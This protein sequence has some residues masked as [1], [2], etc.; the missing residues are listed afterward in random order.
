MR[1][2]AQHI[3]YCFVSLTLLV[4]ECV[5]GTAF[6]SPLAEFQG[7]VVDDETGEP[8]T[9]FR[10]QLGMASPQKPEEISWSQE[11]HGPVLRQP[12]FFSLQSIK[13]GKTWAR[14]L[15]D[16]YLPQPVTAEPVVSPV[17]ITD[18][19]VR[20]KR[21]GELRGIVRNHAG[22]AVAG[23]RV[24]LATEQSLDLTDGNPGQTFRGSTAITDAE[25]RF[26]L[27][28]VGGT[29]QKVVVLSADG[30]QIWIAPKAETGQELKITLPEPAT[31][32]VRYDIPDDAPK[33][34]LR[35]QLKTWELSSMKGVTFV[36]QPTVTNQG[37]VVLTDLAPGTYDLTRTKM[38][39]VGTEAH[40]QFY[41]RSTVVLQAAQT[42]QV[43]FVRTTGFPVRGEVV[44][45]T[46][47]NASGAFI[48]VR[49]AE[50]TGDPRKLQ[51]LMLPLFDVTMCDQA[52]LEPGTYTIVVEAFIPEPPSHTID[53]GIRLPDYIGTA[54]VTVSAVT[55]PE[56]VKIDLSPRPLTK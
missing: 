54:K 4:G 35:L 12:G 50:A 53:T 40:G 16:G 33:T 48:Y 8:V 25:G 45:L 11:F 47:A 26:T 2:R 43:D 28:G 13:K 19:V 14:V 36:Q 44:G 17:H 15:A 39:R 24:F 29:E 7:H 21:G 22:R 52:G 46:D 1:I 38:L 32:I 30:L 49:S 18:L 10:V 37:Q 34:Q 55:P 41:G 27:R 42:Q 31:L 56:P 51:E 9:D 23:A 5:C 20:L 6:E 3:F